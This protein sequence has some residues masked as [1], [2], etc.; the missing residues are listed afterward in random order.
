MAKEMTKDEGKNLVDRNPV[1]RPEREIQTLE[2]GGGASPAP[3]IEK[4][5]P[6]ELQQT[7][8]TLEAAVVE[9]NRQLKLKDKALD[10][11]RAEAEALRAQQTPAPESTE[12]PDMQAVI[13]QEM[14]R[15]VPDLVNQVNRTLGPTIDEARAFKQAKDEAAAVAEFGKDVVEQYRQ[16]ADEIRKDN[17]RLSFFQAVKVVAPKATVTAPATP[18]ESSRSAPPSQPKKLD[19]D[20][21][22]KATL[23]EAKRFGNRGD[24]MLLEPVLQRLVQL[25]APSCF[26]DRSGG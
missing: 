13:R 17:P 9:K 18:V 24:T 3:E 12:T 15:L 5:S 4:P 1:P 25:R 2:I 23:E 7:I 10:D 20:A 6:E 21:E 11:K 16:S 22:Y 26:P 8:A 14:A 19:R